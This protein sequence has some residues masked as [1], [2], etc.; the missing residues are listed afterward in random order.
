MPRFLK[1]SLVSVRDLALTYAPALILVVIA[2]WAAYV[3]IDPT[4]PSKVILSTGPE[5]SAYEAYAKQYKAILAKHH[6]DVEFRPS[7]GSRE[8]LKRL[9]DANSDVEVGFVQSG[10]TGLQNSEDE[11]EDDS[12]GLVSL[13]SMFV[14]PVWLFYRE[15]SPS[16]TT[17]PGTEKV[18]PRVLEKLSDLRGLKVNLGAKG[19][20]GPHIATQLL[21]AN[22]IERTDLTVSFLE[23]TP[24]VVAL[25][26]GEIDAVLFTS[27]SDD[28]LIQMLLQTPGI[29]L[30][31][32]DQAEAYTRRF[33]YLSHVGL[34]RGIV[35]L[36]RDL[37]PEDINL[38]APTATL[39]ARSS[40]HPAI[41]ELLVQAAVEVHGGAGWFRKAGEF[42]NTEYTEIPVADEA[43]RYFKSGKPWLQ[44]YLPFW[45]ANLIE[46]MWII[47][48]PVVALALP[49]SRILPP[50]YTWRVRSRVYRW[51]GLL[52]RVEE[53]VEATHSQAPLSYVE[54]RRQ[55]DSHIKQLDD[56]D[57]RVNRLVVPLSFADEVYA[58]RSHIAM[59]R[60][61]I[62]QR[63]Q[64]AKSPDEAESP[65]SASTS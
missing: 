26:N 11:Q 29:R 41:K 38:I 60:K 43:L 6:I 24:A 16:S 50:L 40:I 27:A 54:R 63:I 31:N 22:H 44:R 62:R 59:V 14:E 2:I 61:M 9:K 32:F 51:Y 23:N 8:N 13:G 65:S 3:A 36:E 17:K 58:L 48:V 7:Q 25:L 10:S 1:F 52:R 18:K 45:L 19:S 39:V 15:N 4:P 12:S 37:P 57:E 34:P 46:R 35:A 5:N 33:A 47:I 64:S 53:E 42:P 20:G 56:I 30:F 55:F 28:P 21:K 49:L